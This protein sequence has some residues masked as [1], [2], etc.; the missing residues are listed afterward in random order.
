[1]IIKIFKKHKIAIISLILAIFC[2]IS[3]YSI[4]FGMEEI[5]NLEFNVG[6]VTANKL[7]VRRGPGV[8]YET[9]GIVSK[10]WMINETKFKFTSLLSNLYPLTKVSN[11]CIIFNNNSININIKWISFTLVIFL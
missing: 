3:I 6:Q 8:K 5:E 4:C 9:V 7:N 11:S 1:M 2:A 10:L